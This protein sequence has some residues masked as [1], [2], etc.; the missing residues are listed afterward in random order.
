MSNFI[1]GQS[2]A[3]GDPEIIQPMVKEIFKDHELVLF[4]N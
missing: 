4:Y 2:L 1:I 3:K